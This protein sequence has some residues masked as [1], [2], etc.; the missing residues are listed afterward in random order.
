MATAKEE[1]RGILDGLPDDVSLEEI[2][3]H[4]Y[5]RQKIEC[6]LADVDAGRV[7]STEEA[8]RRMSRWFGR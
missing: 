2:Q 6:G 5:V 1:V 4:I 7:L 8:A 3:Y